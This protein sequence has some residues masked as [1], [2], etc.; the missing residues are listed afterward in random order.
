MSWVEKREELVDALTKAEAEYK[1]AEKEY[2]E[3]LLKA[4]ALLKTLT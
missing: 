4:E 2:E 3:C 1:E